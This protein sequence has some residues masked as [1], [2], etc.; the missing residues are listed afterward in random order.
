MPDGKGGWT[1]GRSELGFPAGKNKTIVIRLDDIPGR[2]GVARRFRLRTNM[3]IYWDA[4]QYAEGLD[5][6]LARQT[7]LA[8][9]DGGVCAIAAFPASRGPTRVPRSCPTMISW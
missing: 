7:V 3:E 6:G 2:N 4:L 9:R 1:V 8:A 5:A